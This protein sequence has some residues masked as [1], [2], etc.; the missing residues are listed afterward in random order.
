MRVTIFQQRCDRCL[1]LARQVFYAGSGSGQTLTGNAVMIDRIAAGLLNPNR[2]GVGGM[3]TRTTGWAGQQ[4]ARSS[5]RP[6]EVISISS[7]GGPPNSGALPSA[8][9]CLNIAFTVQ[10][11]AC[12]GLGL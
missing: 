3:I 6:G 11:S 1:G 10:A 7:G 9:R 2:S 5:R 12:A 4:H 8:P